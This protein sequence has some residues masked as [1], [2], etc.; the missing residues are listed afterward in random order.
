[1]HNQTLEELDKQIEELKQRRKELIK[2]LTKE[3][4]LGLDEHMEELLSI[5]RDNPGIDAAKILKLA[6]I[7][8]EETYSN[9]IM[10]LCRR[11]NLI[12][13]KGTRRRPQWYSV[14]K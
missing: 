8:T 3:K 9:K 12:V 5:V 6:K 7:N 4:R 14:E 13:N 2:E 11:R 10:A 1:M